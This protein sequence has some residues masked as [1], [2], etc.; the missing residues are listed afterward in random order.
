MSIHNQV[1][2][3]AAWFFFGVSGRG[4]SV[5]HRQQRTLSSGFQVPQ[6]GQSID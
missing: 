5:L 2:L 1:V 4:N 6:L 3:N